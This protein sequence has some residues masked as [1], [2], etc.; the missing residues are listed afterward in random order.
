M[1]EQIVI[2]KLSPFSE[3]EIVEELGA[4]GSPGGKSHIVLKL[5][6]LVP[7]HDTYVEPFAGGAALYWKKEPVKTEVLNDLDKDIAQAYMFI[8]NLDEGTINKV[9]SM[10][11]KADKEKFFKL[12]DSPVPSDPVQRF[13]RF[14]Y[15][16]YNSY[17]GSRKTYG[18]K[19]KE[20]TCFDKYLSYSERMKNTKVFSADYGKVIRKFDSPSTFIYLDPPYP[21]EWPGH[22]GTKSWGEKQVNE[23]HAILKSCKAKWLLSINDLDWI[24]KIF[25]DFKIHKIMVP[26]KFKGEAKGGLKEKYE[27]LISN[28]DIKNL[29]NSVESLAQTG[30]GSV[31]GGSISGGGLQPIWIFG[32]KRKGKN[33]YKL[34]SK[35]LAELIKNV[36]DYDVSKVNDAQLADDWRIT[37][38]W[39]S[40]YIKAGG[41]G[42]KFSKETIVNIAKLIYD[43]IV[44]RVKEGK[45]KHEFKV[46]SMTPNALALYK[47][48]SSGNIIENSDS[49]Q[50]LA[51]LN[52]LDDFTVIKDCISL[53]GSSITQEHTPHDIDLLIR[54]K[55]PDSSF[56]KRAVEIR[57]SKMVPKEFQNKLHF[58]WGE[59]EGPHDSFMPLYDLAF[60]R[61][62][63]TRV[64]LMA[65]SEVK[66]FKPYLPQKPYGSA[67]YDLNK[68]L[69]VYKWEEK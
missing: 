44:K 51:Y 16:H 55:E 20:P 21:N 13:Y 3:D 24:R 46:E 39:Y 6:K 42:I 59:K 57:L 29:D 34:S 8:K 22:T 66:L 54:M 33:I 52:K 10:D 25:S 56:M 2:K 61:I 7:K 45:M 40:T 58:V 49:M 28:Y 9:K 43:E 32:K 60:R 41:K 12:R 68:F 27:L 17:G 35:N 65:E 1:T 62:K 37:N 26:R 50:N 11:W 47:I 30:S 18:Y 4:F 67:F 14:F 53:I 69:E 63:N 64:I 38:A 48:V 5:L 31:Q 23:L 19:T 15:V 36:N